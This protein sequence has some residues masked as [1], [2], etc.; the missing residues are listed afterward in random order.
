[1]N[2]INWLKQKAKIYDGPISGC[3]GCLTVMCFG[4]R[5]TVTFV[6]FIMFC[7]IMLDLHNGWR[8]FQ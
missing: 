8:P 3:I 4:W 1:M 6:F 7:A 5:L 2:I